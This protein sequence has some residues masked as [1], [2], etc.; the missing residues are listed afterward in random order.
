[1]LSE[2]ATPFNPE[3]RA[4]AY[5][6]GLGRFM[7]E[8]PKL[9]DAGDYN[10]FRYCHNDPIDFTD[11]MG[12]VELEPWPTHKQQA[13]AMDNAYNFIMGLMQRQFSSAISAGMAGHQAYQAW[14]A[15]QG[16]NFI[17]A[18]MRSS[19][20]QGDVQYRYSA[21][22]GH[23]PH[24][25]D[26]KDGGADFHWQLNEYYP[27]SKTLKALKEYG[28]G[29][30]EIEIGR[31]GNIGTLDTSTAKIVPL[32][33]KGILSDRV[34]PVVLNPGGTVHGTATLRN[35]LYQRIGNIWSFVPG[36]T[37]QFTHTYNRGANGAWNVDSEI[38]SP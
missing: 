15:V 25:T 18:Q 28:W 33:S 14:S 1:V 23:Q 32:S 35:D 3:Y 16:H 30:R 12:T 24:R 27:D 22:Q 21:P 8:D 34:A 17:M 13:E 20:A 26:L 2:D 38:S 31:T 36:M 19:N 7:S 29:N 9:F 10:L 11:P 6:P 5:H 4:R 37:T